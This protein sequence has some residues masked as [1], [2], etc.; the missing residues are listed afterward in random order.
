MGDSDWTREEYWE[1]L[2]SIA[3]DILEECNIRSKEEFRDSEKLSDRVFERVDESAWLM[4]SEE[5]VMAWTKNANALV[6]EYGAD[7]LRGKKGWS[8]IVSAFAWSAFRADLDA[9][10][11]GLVESLP[12]SIEE[13][14]DGQ[15]IEEE[16]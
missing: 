5:E 13:E 8:E 1:N 3:M 14:G 2:R 11:W 7:A 16:E 15:S 10:I 9:E 4:Y 12:E 6:E